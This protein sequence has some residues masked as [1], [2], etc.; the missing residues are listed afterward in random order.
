M[1][2]NNNMKIINY[3]LVKNDYCYFDW[4]YSDTEY[5]SYIENRSNLMLTENYN[6]FIG[7]MWSGLYASNARLYWKPVEFE[8][9][10]LYG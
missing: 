6:I 5:L 2:Y 4:Q 8:R 3:C 1:C 10:V 9:N 7:N